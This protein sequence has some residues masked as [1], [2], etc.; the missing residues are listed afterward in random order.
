M[1]DAWLG[2]D[3]SDP[4]NQE[5]IAVLK[6]CASQISVYYLHGNHDFLLSEKFFSET[7]IIPLPNF[8]VLTL[9]GKKILLTHGDAF[10]T[11]AHLFQLA[12]KFYYNRACQKF[13]LLLPLFIRRSIA[14]FLANQ[15]AHR[16]RPLPKKLNV[17]VNVILNTMKRTHTPQVIH[18]HL[19]VPAITNLNTPIDHQDAFEIILPTWSAQ[20]GG[21]LK[22]FENG[23]FLLEK[24]EFE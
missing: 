14:E 22:Y 21:Y 6:C 7:N 15:D 11:H 23:E 12:R 17:D 24:F 3:D 13:F 19:H 9:Y 1:F 2:D 10:C 8:F 4:L 5:A 20:K 16:P 18:G